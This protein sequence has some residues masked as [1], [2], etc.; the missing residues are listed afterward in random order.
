MSRPTRG[1]REG[2]DYVVVWDGTKNRVNGKYLF[3]EVE[4]EQ[5]M[6]QRPTRTLHQL[7]H[8]EVSQIIRDAE[9]LTFESVAQRHNV[10]LDVVEH[11]AYAAATGVLVAR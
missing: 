3:A 4:D 5:Q 10:H 7:E 11:I 8:A 1:P 9:V 6:Q 2:A